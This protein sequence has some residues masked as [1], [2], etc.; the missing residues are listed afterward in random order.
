MTPRV[1]E[2]HKQ[3][4]HQ[5][6]LRAAETLFAQKGYNAASMDD[7]VNES[8]LSKGA[9]YGHF[10]SKEALFLTIQ[11]KQTQAGIAEI[12]NLFSSDDTPR[13][14]LEKIAKINFAAGCEVPQEVCRMT[15]EFFL[16]AWKIP[17]LQARITQRYNTIR[18]FLVDIII[19]GQRQGEFNPEMD[20]IA[21]ASILIA[22]L[23]G[24]G[25]H[26]VSTGVTFDNKVILDTF[27]K[28][29]SEGFY[30]PSIGGE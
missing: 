6:I 3:D 12:E 30:L 10:V 17:I 4:I 16:S 9:I 28:T 23:D 11:E 15:Y 27:L 25:L 24:L 20:P 13:T 18:Q 29:V 7:I 22:T 5:K 14:K 8:G 26:N 2:E 1:T 19:D 21:L